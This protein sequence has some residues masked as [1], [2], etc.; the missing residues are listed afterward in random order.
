MGLYLPIEVQ[1]G[2]NDHIYR[3]VY[4]TSVVASKFYGLPK[5][6]KTGSP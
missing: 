2:P 5:L 3:K 4:P 1:G 6:H